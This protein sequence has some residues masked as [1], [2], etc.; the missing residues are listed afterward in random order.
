MT[1]RLVLL[2]PSLEGK[3]KRLRF[4]S[5][6]VRL[7]RDPRCEVSFTGEQHAVVSALHAEVV[8]RDGK[9]VLVHRSQSNATLLNDRP[10]DGDAQLFA[11]DR[12]RLGNSGPQIV[13]ESGEGV[14]QR[15]VA[16]KP[17]KPPGPDAAGANV[18]FG[19]GQGG[20]IGR[21]TVLC[22]FVLDHPHVSRRHA[23]IRRHDGKW[24][25]ADEGSAN[26]TFINGRQIRQETELGPGDV[27]DIGPFSLSLDGACLRSCSRRNNISLVASGLT[28]VVPGA[29]G[30]GKTALLNDIAFG[31]DPGEFICVLG[32]SGSGKSTLLGVASGRRNPSGGS[33]QVNGRDL[34]RNF[35]A[36]KEDIVVVPQSCGMHDSLSV[37]QTLDFTAALRL[38]GDT[39]PQERR[40]QVD[41]FLQLTGIDHRAGTK[42]RQLSGG[43]LKRLGLACELVSDPSLLFLDEVTSGLDE[44][45]DLEMMQLFRKL[46]D[47]GKTVLCVTH[48][49][50]HVEQC[51][52]RLLVLTAGGRVAF[53]GKPDETKAWF[54]VDSLGELYARLESKAP[55]RWAAE[56]QTSLLSKTA[57]PDR[58]PTAAPA[59]LAPA[60]R[61]ESGLA[62]LVGGLFHQTLILTR[63]FLAVIAG[64]LP[65]LAATFGQAILVTFLMCLVFGAITSGD[66]PLSV[67]ARRQELRNLLFLVCVSCFW[68]GANNSA[69]EIVK[70]RRIYERER[71]FNLLPAAYWISKLSV[72]GALGS[73][74]AAILSLTVHWWCEVPGDVSGFLLAAMLVTLVGS[75]LGLAISA[76]A[77][78]EELASA[79]VPAV[80]IPQIILAGV[81]ASLSDLPLWIARVAVSAYWGQHLL[82]RTI[83]EGERLGDDESPLAPA[84]IAAL[85]VHAILFMAVTLAGL[86]LRARAVG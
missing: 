31:I 45:A 2:V 24:L 22:A 40:E 70:E 39:G 20:L 43:Q 8:S 57:S 25:V 82:E 60:G 72:L 7:G 23:R 61:R 9:A 16:H 1:D 71:N 59:V 21:D 26:G 10:V 5:A 29:G 83:P 62:N 15:T 11:G 54:Q 76:N 69:K 17:G 84:C 51:C 34:H 30:K 12:I 63:R 38:P 81:V 53:F 58:E 79:L 14:G 52:H 85:A 50:A 46:A 37:Y 49:L 77:R 55:E 42:V 13:V 4:S 48:N 32:P 65:A 78:T 56:F 73:L 47:T 64:D 18:G 67:I 3:P 6:Q 35:E 74:Q 41:A 80:V 33:V 19:L 36:L 66:A 44:K 86:K 27:L 68:L 75:C 28:V